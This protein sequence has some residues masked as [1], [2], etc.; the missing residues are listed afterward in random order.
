MVSF[1]HAVSALWLIRASQLLVPRSMLLKPRPQRTERTNAHASLVAAEVLLSLLSSHNGTSAA[2][3][4][5]GLSRAALQ[6]VGLSAG[7]GHMSLLFTASR[8][9]PSKVLQRDPQRDFTLAYLAEH[10]A[11]ACV[12]HKGT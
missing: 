3:S 12:P 11:A 8:R 2:W 1:R 4:Q 6:T 10:L 7:R 9:N 5:A